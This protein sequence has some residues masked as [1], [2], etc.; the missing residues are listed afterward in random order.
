MHTVLTKTQSYYLSLFFTSLSM[1][2]LQKSKETF[3]TSYELEQLLD[4]I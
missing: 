3:Q 2:F 1:L 4:C